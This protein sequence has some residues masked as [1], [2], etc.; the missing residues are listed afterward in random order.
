[1]SVFVSFV[2]VRLWVFF[3]VDVLALYSFSMMFSMM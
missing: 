3:Y 1:M 2:W